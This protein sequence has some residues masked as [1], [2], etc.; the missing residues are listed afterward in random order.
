MDVLSFREGDCIAMES[1]EDSVRADE[2]TEN[3]PDTE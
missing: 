1:D 3:A 2:V